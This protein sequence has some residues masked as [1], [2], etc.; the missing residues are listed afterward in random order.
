MP[1]EMAELFEAKGVKTG[2]IISKKHS[3]ASVSKR[4]DGLKLQDFCF[5]PRNDDVF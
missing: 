4:A 1:I 2:G 5:V 3:D